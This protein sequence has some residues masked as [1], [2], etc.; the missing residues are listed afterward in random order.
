MPSSNKK[1]PPRLPP[2]TDEDL[3]FDQLR[4]ERD[5]YRMLYYYAKAQIPNFRRPTLPQLYEWARAR[6]LLR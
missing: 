1:T 2:R 3:V 4:F 5:Q 6:R